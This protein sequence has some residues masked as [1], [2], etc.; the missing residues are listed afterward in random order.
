MKTH[1]IIEEISDYHN[2]Q[3]VPGMTQQQVSAVQDSMRA[4]AVREL[5]AGLPGV[6]EQARQDPQVG[7]LTDRTEG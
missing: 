3:E 7:V 2:P 6:A 4:S 5:V 1:K